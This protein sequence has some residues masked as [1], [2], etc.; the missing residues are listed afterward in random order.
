MLQAKQEIQQIIG[1]AVTDKKMATRKKVAV[2]TNQSSDDLFGDHDAL[3]DALK[4]KDEEVSAQSNALEP[5]LD[6]DLPDF[7]V[8]RRTGTEG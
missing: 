5:G 2:V 6:D 3:N 8:S 4:S 7:G 1:E